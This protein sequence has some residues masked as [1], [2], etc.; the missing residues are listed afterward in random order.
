MRCRGS[1]PAALVLEDGTIFRGCYFGE[2]AL[3]YGEVVFTTTMYGYP[4]SLTD[5]SYRGQILVM[6]HPMVGNY[7]VPS[8]ELRH[9]K[10]GLPLH[11]ESEKIQVEGFVIAKL[12]KPSHWSSVATLDEWLRKEGVPGIQM[13]D[14]RKLVKKIREEGVKMAMIVP[15]EKIDEALGKLSSLPRYDTIDFINEVMPRDVIEH[16]EG[17]TVALIDCGAK[18]GII[19]ELTERNLRVLRIPCGTDLDKYSEEIEGVVLANGPG[20]PMIAF[21]KYGIKKIIESAVEYRFPILAICL[22]H[23]L[24]IMAF[25]AEVYKM[26]Y[27]HRGVNKPVKDTN[28]K[29]YIVSENHGYAVNLDTLNKNIFKPWF[30]NPDDRTLEGVISEEKKIFSTQF[31]PE[32]SPGPHD[33]RWIFDLYAKAVRGE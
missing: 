1:E 10:S 9:E 5:P 26:K 14:T 29:C 4:E 16:G 7:G 23:Q 12:T 30:F 11:Y 8:K 22:G 33:T 25:G 32:S 27:G 2:P 6:T 18:Y 19:R 17:T 15:E 21:E 31:H 20:N 24:L 13:V 3:K 28:A